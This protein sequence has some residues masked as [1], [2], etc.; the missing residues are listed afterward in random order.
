MYSKDPSHPDYAPSIFV[1]K[2]SP[3]AEVIDARF[4]RYNRAKKRAACCSAKETKQCKCPRLHEEEVD[5]HGLEE[6]VD[7]R[8]DKQEESESLKQEREV[9]DRERAYTKRE[10]EFK[11]GEGESTVGERESK[12]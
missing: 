12:N 2:P 7:E 4:A 9:T 5:G 1:Y 8:V 6:K 10:G 11:E 3:P